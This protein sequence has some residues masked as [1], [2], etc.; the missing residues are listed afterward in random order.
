MFVPMAKKE[1]I[2]QSPNATYVTGTMYMGYFLHLTKV[3]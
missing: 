2:W 1:L 3:H